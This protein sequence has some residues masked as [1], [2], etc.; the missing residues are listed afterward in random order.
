MG[1]SGNHAEERTSMGKAIGRPL[2]FPEKTI[3][4]MSRGTLKEMRRHMA[5]F[6][7]GQGEYLRAIVAYHVNTPFDFVLANQLKKAKKRKD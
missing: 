6:K 3:L 1:M 2:E 7:M 4:R 5:L